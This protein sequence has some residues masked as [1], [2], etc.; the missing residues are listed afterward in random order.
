M[1]AYGQRLFKGHSIRVP[2][3]ALIAALALLP[4]GCGDG[5]DTT[6]TAGETSSGEE[7]PGARD[8]ADADP[9]DLEVIEDWSA[10]LTEGDVE[11]AARYFATPSTAQNGPVLV[12]IFSTD[13]AIA[14]NESLPCGSKVIAARTDGEFTS[15][16][17][18]L[19]SRPGADCGSGAGGTASTAFQIEDGKIVEWR[20][21][22]DLSPDGGGGGGAG[23]GPP[24]AAPV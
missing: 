17:F 14:F 20:R 9:E 2:A 6:I 18:R 19:R 15:A 1:F 11:G 7:K 16:T 23:A 13:D 12:R 8:V 22:D 10:A 5:A 4:A 3:I 21:I 24:D